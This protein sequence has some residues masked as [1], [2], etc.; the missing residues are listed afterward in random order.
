MTPGTHSDSD[1][2][3]RNTLGLIV[4]PVAGLGG[5]VGL[6][7]SDGVEIQERALALGAIPRSL[8]RAVQALE[9][10]RPLD[11][12]QIVTYPGEMGGS[13]A[14]ACGFEP[15]VIG[16]IHAGH[17]RPED[18][19]RAAQD[20]AGRGVDLLLFAG[21]DGTAR[22]IY[23]AVR[24]RLLVLGIPAGVKIHSAVYG[25]SP[26]NAGDLALAF[27][28]GDPVSI[29]EAEVMDIDEEAVRQGVVSAK[30]YGYL[31]IPFR[32][33]LVQTLKAPSGPGEGGA[34]ASIAADVVD[35]MQP[36]WLYIIGPGT[37]TRAITDELGLAKTLIGVDVVLDRALLAEDVTEAQLLALI[38][39]R[40][41]KIVVTP[42][43]GQGYIFGRGNQQISH[44]VIRPLGKENII[45]VSAPAK[46]HSLGGRPLLVDTGDRE[47]DKALSGYITVV[48]GYNEEM[49]Y[50]VSY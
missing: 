49:V 48:T 46:I 26:Q 12:L 4:N 6:K 1:A 39:G 37:T 13:A 44:R 27:L 36:G 31:K 43:G 25:T 30:L 41:A 34:M 35:R 28:R 24:D 11:G 14:R 5:R 8:D 15:E 7:G 32:R 23:N 40:D 38:S 47:L 22:D 18:T 16:A 29:R 20:I 3:T 45:V 17:T 21:G 2:G 10:L 19:R 42:I 50:R 9:R 33:Q